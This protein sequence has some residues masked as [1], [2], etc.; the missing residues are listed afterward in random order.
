VDFVKSSPWEKTSEKALHDHVA[1][2]FFTA[3][4]ALSCLQSDPSPKIPF[5]LPQFPLIQHIK[6]SQ[7]FFPLKENNPLKNRKKFK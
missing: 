7:I 6:R 3:S 4:F 5:S 1:T 2:A